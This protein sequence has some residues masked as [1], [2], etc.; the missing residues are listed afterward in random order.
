MSRERG[1]TGLRPTRDASEKAARSMRAGN[2]T[3]S[4]GLAGIIENLA[5]FVL[6]LIVAMRPLLSETYSS[7]I[8]NISQAAG[9]VTS[10]SPATT[11]VF[12]LAIWLAAAG[13]VAS[14]W[15]KRRSWHWT[16]L[17]IGWAIMTA[18]AVVSSWAASQQ[19]AG[20]QRLVRLAHRDRS[21]YGPGQPSAWAEAGDPRP[22]GG[23]GIRAGLGGQVRQVSLDGST[24]TPTRSIEEHKREFWARRAFR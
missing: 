4:P 15:L 23:G 14:A 3:E 1:Q 5:F 2:G 7:S 21:G 19:T 8:S 10:L 22:G 9:D 24:Q 11:A 17:E 20:D 13:A 18:A 12:D 16:G 6:I